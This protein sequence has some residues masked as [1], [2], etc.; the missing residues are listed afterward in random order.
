MR[1]ELIT[2]NIANAYD[3]TEISII[4]VQGM[5]KERPELGWAVNA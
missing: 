2:D 4:C 3:A 5:T 1:A